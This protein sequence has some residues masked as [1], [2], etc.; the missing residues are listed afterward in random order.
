[1]LPADRRASDFDEAAPMPTS[2]SVRR[3]GPC[4]VTSGM[5]SGCSL[6]LVGALEGL[7]S[8]IGGAAAVLLAG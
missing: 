4:N 7:L 5:I 2:R 6:Q 8:R 3:A 1:L